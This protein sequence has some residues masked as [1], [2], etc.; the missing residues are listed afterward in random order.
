MS[1]GT[2]MPLSMVAPGKKVR[3]VRING[4]RNLRSRLAA[5]GLMP[6]TDVEVISGGH[7]GPCVV[8]VRDSRL[9]LGRGMA[10]KIEVE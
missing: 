7:G 6:G 2:L 9:I 5:M 10:L 3:L 4:G 1:G 8:S